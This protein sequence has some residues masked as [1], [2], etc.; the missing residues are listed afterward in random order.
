MDERARFIRDWE[1][2]DLSFT[3]LCEHYGI[4]RTIGYKWVGRYEI[5][6]IEGLKDHSRRPHCS[7]ARTPPEIVERVLEVRRRHP[8]WGG[9]KIVGF[10]ER[11]GDRTIPGA[12]TIDDMLRRHGLTRS[13][14]RR[15]RP[16]HP[17][18]PATT[19]R[20][21][22]ELWTAD[23]KG[24]FR[25]RTG[26]Y[27]Y[28]LTVADQ[29]SR[30]L[31]ACT[32]RPSTA[33]D[34]AQGVF[35]RL[36]RDYGLPLAIR[37]DN[38]SPFA[39]A[40]LARLSRLSVWWIK[41]GIHPELIEPASPQQ[42]GTHERMH[43]TLKAEATRP[44]AGSFAAQQRCFNRF[45]TIFNQDRP[46]EA[47]D[48]SV[49]ADLYRPSRRPYPDRLPPIEY[50]AHFEVRYVSRNNGIRWKRYWV[51][52]SAVLAQEH[53]GLEEID[54]GIWALYFANYLLARLNER[55]RRLEE[56]ATGASRR[57]QE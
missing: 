47:L 22:N 19:A 21:A 40:G 13:R 8:T 20:A 44:P 5:A 15:R 30:Y 57:L 34:G 36:F 26:A 46:H 27:C 16:G 54:D 55:T 56:L 2:A 45:R 1:R 39:S 38:G 48:Q 7:P 53:V 11:Q 23:F 29:F 50:P 52:V 49:P 9:W 32:A 43:R 35:E 12:S 10:L 3:E 6:G 42:N 4:S 24:Q 18:R 51:N 41:L 37:T 17:G 31:L 28:P 25:L 33:H 14:P